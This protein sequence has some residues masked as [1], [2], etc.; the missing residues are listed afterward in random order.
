V[1][2]G[3]FYSVL[4]P[5]WEGY[6]EFAHF[7]FV[8]HLV[9]T[10]TLPLASTPVSKEVEESLK[11]VPLPWT[12]RD[13]G[14]PHAIHDDYWM[15]SGDERRWREEQLSALPRD[16]ASQPATAKHQYLSNWEA[17]QPPLY[18]WLVSFPLRIVWNESLPVR[19]LV[20]RLLGVGMASLVIPLGFLIALRVFRSREAAL[21][22]AALIAAMPELF[23]NVCRVGN[24]GLAI[25]L[26]SL[27]IYAALSFAEGP[28]RMRT[29]WLFGA[30]M[31]LGLLTKAYFLTALPAFAVVLTCILLFE[32]DRRGAILLRGLAAIA[33]ALMICGWWYWRNHT[34]TGSW[35]GV[36]PDVALH[37][38]P[39][40]ELLRQIPRV[41]WKN[42]FDSL[43]LSHIWFGNWSFL[44][45]RS[46]IYHFYKYLAL[47]ASLG[48][49]AIYLVPWLKRS[50]RLT[51]LRS[52]R[53]LLVPS[54]FYGFF[55][56]GLLYHILITFVAQG[57]SASQGWYLYCLVAAEVI[58]VMAGLLALSPA[59]FQPWVMPAAT[60]G[61]SLL[62]IYTVH[63]LL[64]PYYAGLIAHKADGA[65]ATF[66]VGMLRGAD[67][68]SYIGRLAANEPYLNH[69]GFLMIWFFYLLATSGLVAISL[70]AGWRHCRDISAG[71]SL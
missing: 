6:D 21:G 10:G 26:Y 7:A 2:R 47:L 18:Y 42:A 67:L 51:F 35:S 17:Q 53:S 38:M 3:I 71:P 31:G 12:L 14:V 40:W 36:M 20:L 1:L 43:I 39:L 5:L 13:M 54:L 57:I 19:V 45:V 69:A 24:E 58:V 50:G 15:L 22:I 52:R 32:P 9:A 65:L 23:V 4:F 49:V 41:D 30:C 66:H 56:L 68:W 46:W 55:W 27:L 61:F 29:I 33:A 59:R 62:D 44:Q 11:L 16:W 48:L 25:L 60:I 64:A 8:Q 34:L 37:K 70:R 28:G 63:F